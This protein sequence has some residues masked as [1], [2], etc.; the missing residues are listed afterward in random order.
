MTVKELLELLNRF[1]DNDFAHHVKKQEDDM[2]GFRK[3]QARLFLTLLAGL[4][5]IV[6]GLLILIL[7]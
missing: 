3:S 2:A 7:R 1:I 4:L 5:S 6:S